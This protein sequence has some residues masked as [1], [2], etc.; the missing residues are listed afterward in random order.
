M[1]SY[2]P[3]DIK[4]SVEIPKSPFGD[5]EN[6]TKLAHDP[7]PPY[8]S[9][10]LNFFHT[11]QLQPFNHHHSAKNYGARKPATS[12]RKQPLKQGWAMPAQSFIYGVKSC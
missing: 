9:V 4:F 10:A 3:P 1:V 12:H 11:H 5:I 8:H 6:F 2:G 7:I